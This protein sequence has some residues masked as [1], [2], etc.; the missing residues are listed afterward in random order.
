MSSISILSLLPKSSS[1]AMAVHLDL[2]LVA[3]CSFL[4]NDSE[5]CFHLDLCLVA[6][7]SFLNNDSEYCWYHDG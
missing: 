4:N 1:V 3:S 5:Y 2:C 6:S 7:C